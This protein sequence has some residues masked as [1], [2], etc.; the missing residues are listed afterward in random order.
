MSARRGRRSRRRRLGRPEGCSVGLSPGVSVNPR[1]EKFAPEPSPP[2]K[3]RHRAP[4]GKLSREAPIVVNGLLL[5]APASFNFVDRSHGPQTTRRGPL[6]QPH[7]RK[8]T[9]AVT[10]SH[11]DRA[12]QVA[13]DGARGGITKN[14]GKTTAKPR[15]NHG[16][17]TAKP[18]RNHGE[19]AAKLR[20]KIRSHHILAG[21]LRFL[22]AQWQRAF[23]P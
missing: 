14:H 1:D 23:A 12:V 4:L 2:W 5:A 21:S 16:E 15:Q 6:T 7:L 13:A 17:T 11:N 19:T 22:R 3:I 8:K 20:R 18:R 10:R 9:A